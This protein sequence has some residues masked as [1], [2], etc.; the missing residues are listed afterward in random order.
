M[1]RN[2][3][4]SSD[5]P[6]NRP[7]NRGPRS[8]TTGTY[9]FIADPKSTRRPQRPE[10]GRSANGQM[11]TE[12]HNWRPS[13]IKYITISPFDGTSQLYIATHVAN[14]NLCLSEAAGD[15]FSNPSRQT[16]QFNFSTLSRGQFPQIVRPVRSVSFFLTLREFVDP[17]EIISIIV[18]GR[19][20]RDPLVTHPERDSN[21]VDLINLII[22]EQ[23]HRINIMGPLK[24][25]WI[26]YFPSW[27]TESKDIVLTEVPVVS[28]SNTMSSLSPTL[29]SADGT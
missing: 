5:C 12:L 27:W 20:S 4:H 16:S 13:L 18:T 6:I 17:I 25:P 9:L 22:F 24:S 11:N 2:R 14:P 23:S 21:L 10:N 29:R 19:K 7:L 8:S 15:S 26:R 3:P 28:A 1:T